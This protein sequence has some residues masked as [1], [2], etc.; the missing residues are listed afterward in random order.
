MSDIRFNM[1]IDVYKI[2]L[3]AFETARQSSLLR[4]MIITSSSIT[5]A[6]VIIIAT[7]LFQS[8]LHHSYFTTIASI[9]DIG[10]I[11]RLLLFVILTTIITSWAYL[12]VVSIRSHL[13]TPTI[14][15]KKQ[16]QSSNDCYSVFKPV[17]KLKQFDNNGDHNST[18]VVTFPFVSVIIP[19]RDEQ[20]HIG[21]CLLSLLSQN[22]PNFEVIAIDDNSTDNTLNIMK[23]IQSVQEGS[24][25][26]VTGGK[27]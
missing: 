24:K 9:A 6:I 11:I 19:A 22:Y 25:S 5:A 10:S 4:C 8:W 27:K 18:K 23:Y 3:M 26:D 13:L 16:D 15:Q 2:G 21:N 7:S 17:T 12:F 20:D 14:T 1:H